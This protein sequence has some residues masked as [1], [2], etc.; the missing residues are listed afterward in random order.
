[1]SHFLPIDINKFSF[2]EREKDSSGK[3]IKNK[4]WRDYFYYAL[5]YLKPGE[6]NINHC[7]PIE[8][9]GKL[10]FRFSPVLA[11]TTLQFV[12][13]QKFL[14]ENNLALSVN[15]YRVNSWLN[16]FWYVISNLYV[17]KSKREKLLQYAIESVGSNEAVGL[18]IGMNY[19][20]TLDH[21]MFVQG[22]DDNFFYIFDTR[23]IPGIKYERIHDTYPIY[24]IAINE[25]RKR[26][27][28]VWLVENK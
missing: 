24:K 12:R 10:G 2:Y 7:P 9:E 13:H 25:V 22:F 4:C 20:N 28:R 19:L 11:W 3:Y 27:L 21:V 14:K 15:G 26:I 18:D 17:S 1:M 8:L 23:T 6:F 16:F 5:H